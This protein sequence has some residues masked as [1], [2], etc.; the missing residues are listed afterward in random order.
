MSSDEIVFL[1]DQCDD[2]FLTKSAIAEHVKENHE[3]SI[4]DGLEEEVER[5]SRRKLGP[6][7]RFKRGKSKEE[8]ED[9]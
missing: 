5:K 9:D 8:S 1:C 6:A 7:S 4:E 2:I 3:A